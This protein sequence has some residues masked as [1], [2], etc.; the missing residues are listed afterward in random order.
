MKSRRGDAPERMVEKDLNDASHQRLRH[1]SAEFHHHHSHA[2]AS[3]HDGG[4]HLLQVEDLSMSFSM[5]DPDSKGFFRAKKVFVSAIEKLNVS[6]HAGE[7]MAVVGASGSG[8]TLLADAV[9]ALFEPNAAAC[10]TVWFDGERCE[11]DDLARLR[12]R[13]ISLVPQSVA[14]LD[15]LMKVGKQV[16]GVARDAEDALRRR[17][18]QRALFERYDLGPEVEEMY[19][20][21]LSGGMAR[22]VLLCCALI[23]EPRLIVADE[24]TPG[25]DL[26]LAERA[27]DDLRAFADEGGGVL[28]ITHDI[29][30]ALR[31]ADR[32]AVFKDGTVVEETSVASF[33][34]PEGLRHPF[35]RELWHAVFDAGG[36]AGDECAGDAGDCADLAGGR[37]C[38]TKA[39]SAVAPAIASHTSVRALEARGI[40]FAHPGGRTLFNGLDLCVAPGERV[41]LA[42]PSG[43]GKTTLC[44]ILAGYLTPDAGEVVVDGAALPAR[45]MRPVQL[46]GQHPETMVDPRMCM[47]AIVE[48]AGPVSEEVV[49]GLGIRSSWMHRHP[50]ELSGGE[51]QRFCIARALAADPR[52]LI[53]DEA[54]AMFDAVA[55]AEVWRFLMAYAQRKDMGIV[56]VS[57]SPSLVERVATRVVGLA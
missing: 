37:E 9:F 48:E 3:A 12:G 20:F 39:H 57:H 27:L 46:I 14:H 11:A 33:R 24:P 2:S 51:L 26:D 41:A 52:Y 22:R 13:G 10:G 23:D 31:V 54:T 32:V 29:E 17:N 40:A 16:R 1:A 5:Y 4:H 15:P 45:G 35:T 7:V 55:Q 53:C 6:V 56:L 28:L 42:A 49:E 18:E 43:F 36:Q 38:G 8:K 34:S 50:H 44:R 21:E 25:L 30:L 19:P 47:R